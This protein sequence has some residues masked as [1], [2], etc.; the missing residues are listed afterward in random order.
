[1]DAKL[2]QKKVA[3]AISDVDH[4]KEVI[5]PGGG[6]DRASFYLTVIWKGPC[7]RHCARSIKTW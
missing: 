3:D 5:S 6:G 2:I 7:A 1:V 4:A